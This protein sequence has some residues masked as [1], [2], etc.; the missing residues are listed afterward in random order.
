MCVFVL[1]WPGV[2]TIVIVMYYLS[3]FFLEKFCIIINNK[4]GH[5][6]RRP[7][8]R[9]LWSFFRVMIFI[10]ATYQ[11]TLQINIYGFFILNKILV[12]GFSNFIDLR[13]TTSGRIWCLLYFNEFIYRLFFGCVISLQIL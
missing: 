4:N 1:H 11:T 5:D 8:L 2:L 6:L 7:I 13:Y 3:D 10:F 9:K 12:F